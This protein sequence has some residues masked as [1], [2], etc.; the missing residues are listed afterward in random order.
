MN[1]SAKDPLETTVESSLSLYTESQLNLASG[2]T[3]RLLA[4]SIVSAIR[5]KYYLVPY[6][7]ESEQK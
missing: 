4:S 6:T 2:S 3:R 1:K 5:G 7:S